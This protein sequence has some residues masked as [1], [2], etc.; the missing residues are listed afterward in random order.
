MNPVPPN[1]PTGGFQFCNLIGLEVISSELGFILHE[2][3]SET[4]HLFWFAEVSQVCSI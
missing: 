2:V 1:V 4:L 3:C